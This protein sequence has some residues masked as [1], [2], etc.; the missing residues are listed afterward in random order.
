V[1]VSQQVPFRTRHFLTTSLNKS[2]VTALSSKLLIIHS[3]SGRRHN[4]IMCSDKTEMMIYDK[5]EH[6]FTQLT[7]SR[8][9]L[10]T[11]EPPD[12][13]LG[14]YVDSCTA[15]CRV[16]RDTCQCSVPPCQMSKQRYECLYQISRV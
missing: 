2:S 9:I 6:E 10:I 15:T 5:E 1:P 4:G 11:G 12:S 3:M 7:H 8:Q 13:T 16:W 14:L